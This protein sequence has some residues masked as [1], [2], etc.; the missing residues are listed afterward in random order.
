[1]HG[2]DKQGKSIG[3]AIIPIV[4]VN[5]FRHLARDFQGDITRS[6][7]GS[8][9]TYFVIPVNYFSDLVDRQSGTKKNL[10]G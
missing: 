6:W 1:M 9:N 8:R 5:G 2:S 7:H 3:D 10:I 4:N